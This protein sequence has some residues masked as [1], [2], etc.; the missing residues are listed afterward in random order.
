M[1]DRTAPNETVRER[2]GVRQAHWIGAM[3]ARRAPEAA[4]FLIAVAMLTIR[5]EHV[6]PL[7]FD[8]AWL[9]SLARNWVEVGH[10]GHFRD[11]DAIPP[12]ILNTG[13]PLAWPVA[14]SFRLL[15][16]GVWQGRLPGILFTLGAL[17]LIYHLA[18][19]LYD[20]PTAATTLG[21]VLFPPG[22]AVFFALL[23]GQVQIRP[24]MGALHPLL[25]GRMA[26]GE[27][28]ALFFL[29]A[30]YVSFHSAWRRPHL[31][32]PLAACFWGLSLHTKTQILPFLAFSLSVPLLVMAKRRRYKP[33]YLLAAG[34]FGTLVAFVL[35]GWFQDFVLRWTN[36]SNPQAHSVYDVLKDPAS[37]FTYV[38]APSAKI[39]ITTLLLS[40][41][42]GLPLLISVVYASRTICTEVVRN[43]GETNRSTVRLALVALIG[44]WFAWWSLLSIGYLR[45]L[46]PAIF[47]GSIFMA[48]FAVDLLYRA[49]L[50]DSG[51]EPARFLR[52]WRSVPIR[53]RIL[54]VVCLALWFLPTAQALRG[55]LVV[56]AET[57]AQ[58]VAEFFNEKTPS[59]I[60]IETYDSPLF[61]WLNRQYHY[62]PDHVQT[63]INWRVST[64]SEAALEYDPLRADP[65][66]LVVGPMS[67]LFKLYDP[68]LDGGYF[69]LLKKYGDYYGGY[70]VYGRI[71]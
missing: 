22:T 61:L 49:G 50:T 25:L 57:S 63:Q 45:Y 13:F 66:Y 53:R 65:D 44:S 40:I 27:M 58:Q 70:V 30:G 51:G 15:G 41:S 68:V 14:L 2:P 32:I 33:M 31:G 12:T 69:R 26:Y 43:V 19:R 6:P 10:Y 34:L 54:L 37:L 48:V 46:L 3:L 55:I 60:R 42:I 52:Y 7:F 67:R 47:L 56:E 11:G 24:E 28:A 71:R 5:L 59:G 23:L 29:L 18:N 62:P 64:G 17:A 35:L 36:V 21:M 20:R 4:L 38:L 8:E 9:L 1:R 39:R 16:V